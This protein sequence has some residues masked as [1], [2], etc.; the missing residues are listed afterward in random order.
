[1]TE[2]YSDVNRF[3]VILADD[4]DPHVS[5]QHHLERGSAGG[6]DCVARIGT[7]VYA[8][9]DCEITNIPN[10]GSGGNTVTMRFADG[11]RDQFMHLSRFAAPGTKRK[12]ELV[13]Y[14]GDSGSPGAPHVHWHRIDPTGKRR[15]PWDY[16][17][18]SPSGGGGTTPIEEDDMFTDQDRANL[19]SVM[20][21]LGAGGLAPGQWK[22]EDT[23]SAVVRENRAALQRMEP[24]IVN[25]DQQVTGADDFDAK[26]GPSVAGRLIDVQNTVNKIEG[27]P[28]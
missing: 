8:P 1:M 23:V 22:D 13:G 19:E 25:L 9:A 20:L 28:Q 17:T 4:R 11:W 16:F 21:A 26:V 18:S 6:V 12:G 3:V 5:W 14:S 7:P 2:N 24:R 27:S 10:N 15:N